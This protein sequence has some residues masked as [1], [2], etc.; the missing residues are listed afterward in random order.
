MI[1][2]ISTCIYC[3]VGCKLRY[4]VENNKIVKILPHPNDKISEGRPCIKGLTINEVV[5]S[6]RIIKPMK[7]V[8]GKLKEISWKE[9]LSIF[10]KKLKKFSPDEIFF[11]GSGKITNEDNF[12]IQKFARLV[13]K[14]NNIDGCCA[15][16]CHMPSVIAYRDSFG[17][18]ANPNFFIDIYN[19]DL[20][21]VLGSNPA[22]NYPAFFAKVLKNRDRIKIFVIS[23]TYSETSEMADKVFLINP[24]TELLLLNV[25]IKELIERKAFRR[26][27]IGFGDLHKSVI[28]YSIEDAEKICGI[29][30]SDIEYLINEIIKCKNL[31]AMHGMGVTQRL[32]AVET[33]QAL[34]NLVILMKGKILSGRG[35]I[36]VQGC[37]DM[38]TNPEPIQF[39]PDADLENLKKIWGEDLPKEKGMN[40]IEALGFGN[41][42]LAVISAFNP[43][44]SM[45]DLN[46]IHRNLEKM[47]VV[48]FDSYFNLTSYFSD[49][50]LPIP[51]LIERE[52]S[53]TN[54]ERRVEWVEKVIDPP[55]ESIEIWKVF[56]TLAE[57]FDSDKFVYKDELEIFEEITKIVKSYSKIDPKWIKESDIFAEKKEK[58][59]K[60]IPTRFIGVEKQTNQKY[61]FLL[62]TF[63]SKYHFLTNESTGK[64]KTLNRVKYGPYFYMNPNDAK[65]LNLKNLDEVIVESSCGKVNG[66][67]FLSEKI[68]EGYIGAHFHFENLLVNKLY[69][70]EFDKRSFTPNFKLVAVRVRKVR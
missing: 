49:L 56:S 50:I 42:K 40:I 15:R 69:P 9:A 32:Y 18:P 63:R 70:L 66:Y 62:Y 41:A 61:P 34:L 68:R 25:I 4:I 53:I 47:F 67:V 46:R 26:R 17:I 44:Q 29:S 1:E 13:I 64:S 11:T 19:V 43:A 39:N 65:K 2:V 3:G 30:R 28:S 10:Y 6:G 27:P 21:L 38:L 45:P 7:R 31:G 36:N 57:F 58:F 48:Q 14:T 55:G 24:G 33:V 12:I 52:G 22:T 8:E 59:F 23:P 16:L 20:L 37:G 35:E 54:A 5:E 51:L 60:V